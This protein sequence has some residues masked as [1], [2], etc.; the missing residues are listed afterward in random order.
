MTVTHFETLSGAPGFDRQTIFA[1]GR[2]CLDFVNTCCRRRQ[3]DLELIGSGDELR[4][5]L[6]GAEETYSK[7]MVV[8]DGSAPEGY[9]QAALPQALA[10]RS[11]LR[12]V[13]MAVI[14]GVPLPAAGLDEVNR[15]L[16]DNP[17]VLQVEVREGTLRRRVSALRPRDAWLAAIAEDAADLLSAGDLTLLRQCAYPDCIRVFY[18]T[19]K[20]HRRRWCVEKCG[21]HSK[22]A[23]YYRRKVARRREAGE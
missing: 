6:R 12:D 4:K 2:L 17:T 8:D 7:A 21:S 1:G 3:A 18:D 23:A 10:L 9:W 13:V 15:V 22:A 19:T 11:A 16:R 5:W 20:N 14:D